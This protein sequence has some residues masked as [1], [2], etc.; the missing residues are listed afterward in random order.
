MVQ[1]QLRIYKIN[2]LEYTTHKY[3]HPSLFF[4]L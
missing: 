1:P 4:K 2:E 3:V